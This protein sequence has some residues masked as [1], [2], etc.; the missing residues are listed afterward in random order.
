MK[1]FK[2]GDNDLVIRRFNAETDSITE[3]TGLL[4]RAYKRLADM[5]LNF[6]ATYQTDEETKNRITKGE[7]FVIT[8]NDTIIGTVTLYKDKK[9]SQCEWY[10]N[11][12][13]SYFGQ[14]AV[15]PELQNLGIGSKLMEFT[16]NYAEGLGL[17]EIALDT[18]EKAQH[19]IDYYDKRGYRF[20][21]HHQWDVVNYRSVVLSK[22]LS[23]RG[24]DS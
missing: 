1:Q 18:S 16:E 2:A 9:K 11:D 12:G 8:L 4:H 5:G 15:E 7:C 20:V 6:V 10:R 19:L 22:K 13:V 3:L 14:F 23:S 21:Q 24:S 17:T